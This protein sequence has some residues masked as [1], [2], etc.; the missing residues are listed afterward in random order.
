MGTEG[1]QGRVTGK[2]RGRKRKKLGYELSRV[3]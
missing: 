2:E 3:E 1:E